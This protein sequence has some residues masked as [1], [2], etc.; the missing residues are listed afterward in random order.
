VESRVR[1]ATV[2]RV[3]VSRGSGLFDATRVHWR[4][5]Y[6]MS[7]PF[8]AIRHTVPCPGPCNYLPTWQIIPFPTPRREK[9]N[10]WIFGQI[11]LANRPPDYVVFKLHRHLDLEPHCKAR[12]SALLQHRHTAPYVKTSLRRVGNHSRCCIVPCSRRLSRRTPTTKPTL[13][14]SRPR[15]HTPMKICTVLRYLLYLRCL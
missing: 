10:H 1:A 7:R 3:Y 11:S 13:E 9:V 4:S 14:R 6:L 12:F 8:P 15:V 5:T 2:E